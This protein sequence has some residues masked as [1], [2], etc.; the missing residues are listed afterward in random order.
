MEVASGMITRPERKWT[1]TLSLGRHALP[2]NNRESTSGE[3]VTEGAM[4]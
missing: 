1:N 2:S 3:A 4:G